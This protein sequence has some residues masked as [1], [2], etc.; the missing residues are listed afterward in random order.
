MTRRSPLSRAAL[1]L[2]LLILLTSCGGGEA[3]APPPASLPSGEEPL[4]PETLPPD[5]PPAPAVP[6]RTVHVFAAGDDL[7]HRGIYRDMESGGGY[8]FTPIFENLREEISAADLALINQE[9]MFDPAREPS[10]YPLFNTP[11][12]IADDL[13]AIGFDVISLANNHML[14]VGSSGLRRTIDRLDEVEGAVRVGAYLDEADMRAVR[15]LERG[16]LRIAVV[17]FTYGTNGITPDESVAIPYL[18]E[19]NVREQL[20]LAEAAGDFTLVYAHW[21]EEYVFE[22]TEEQRRFAALMA[23]CG[24]DIIVGSHPHV[25]EPV[26]WIE[27]GD[28]GR[29]PCAF[30][31]GNLVSMQDT[32]QT[33]LGGVLSFDVVSRAGGEAAVE[34][35]LFTPTVYYYSRS[36]SGNRIYRLP[37]F[38]EDLAASHGVQNYGASFRLSDLYGILKETIDPALLPSAVTESEYWRGA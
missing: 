14:D 32:A 3:S 28:G 30:S 7:I 25:I 31:L 5:E 33:M 10:N 4:A 38:P 35:L 22:P 12:E 1:L 13:A 36:W 27:R 2:L 29:V 26:E 18:T 20:A 8:D 37:D 24:A 19:E 17:A 16:G 15:V 11:D 6:D 34:N 23:E 9:T 21:G